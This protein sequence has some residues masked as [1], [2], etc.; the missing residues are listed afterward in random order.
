MAYDEDLSSPPFPTEDPKMTVARRQAFA[1][2]NKLKGE[3]DPDA[4]TLPAGTQNRLENFA[5]EV[6]NMTLEQVAGA[7]KRFM[8]KQGGAVNEILLSWKE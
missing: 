3:D 8:E 6:R 5:R 1:A 2:W 7:V 4:E